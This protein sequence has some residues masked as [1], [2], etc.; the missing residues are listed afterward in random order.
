MTTQDVL[1][2]A[3]GVRRSF[4]PQINPSAPAPAYNVVGPQTFAQ[5]FNPSAD[6]DATIVIGRHRKYDPPTV[7]QPV[8]RTP[9]GGWVAR[10][11]VAAISRLRRRPAEGGR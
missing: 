9:R 1:R 11:A 6:P 10:V 3:N 4:P 5:V 2:R 8:Q 7:V